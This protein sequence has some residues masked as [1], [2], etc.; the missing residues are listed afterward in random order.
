M[1]AGGGACG[2]NIILKMATMIVA[3]M[4]A[5]LCGTYQAIR[6]IQITAELPTNNPETGIFNP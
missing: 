2:L 5:P 1:Y 6:Q 4:M 3:L